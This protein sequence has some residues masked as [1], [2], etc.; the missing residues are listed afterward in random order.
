MVE[1]KKKK[2]MFK[3]KN[4]YYKTLPSLAKK[5][6]ISKQE[7]KQLV[8]DINNNNTTIYIEKDGNVGKY[9]YSKEKPLLLKDFGIKKIR[10]S[11]LVRTQGVKGV[12]LANNISIEATLDLN[13]ACRF[14]FVISEEL[15]ERSYTI[16]AEISSSQITDNY[17]KQ[18]IVD[19]YLDTIAGGVVYDTLKILNFQVSSVFTEQ[20]F[21]FKDMELYN[22][23]PKN[24]KIDNLFNEVITN[25]KW[26]DCVYDF[27][28]S[29]YPKLSKKKMKDLRTIEDLTIWSELNKLKMLCYD[30]NG[31]IVASHYP[32]KKNK[33]KNLVFIAFNNHLYPLKNTTLHKVKK[34][35]NTE[36]EII[37]EGSGM[38]LLIEFLTK[39]ILPTGLFILNDNVVS[40]SHDGKKYV[41]NPHHKECLEI[42]TNMGLKDKMTPHTNLMNISKIIE[43][44]YV[45]ENLKSFLP[46]N[47]RFIKGGY[48]YNNKDLTGKIDLNNELYKEIETIDKNKAYSY[49]LQ[50]LPYLLQTDIKC[51]KHNP[52]FGINDKIIDHYLYI[53]EPKQSSILLPDINI[54]T[55]KH[56]NFCKKEG[57]KFKITEELECNKKENYYT[58]LIKDLYGKVSEKQFKTIINVM[59][60]K[61]ERNNE[62][63]QNQ[64]V[65]K[66][67]NQDEVDRSEGYVKRIK[68][69]D[70]SIVLENTESFEL[71]NQKPIAV[72]VKDTARLEIYKMLCNL[73]V[74]NENILQVKTD[75]I[76]FIPK[77]KGYMKYINKTLE[78]WKIEKYTPIEDHTYYEK[79]ITFNYANKDTKNVLGNCYAGAGKTHT[80]LNEIIPAIEKDNNKKLG[81]VNDYIILTPSH[82]TLKEYRLKKY[83]CNVIQRYS[84]NGDIPDEKHII[85]DEIGMVDNQ[86]WN[87][88]YKLFLK[89]RKIY[90][91]GDFKQL[92]AVDG[93]VYDNEIFLNYIFNKQDDIKTNYRNNFTKKYYDD[94]MNC[95]KQDHLISEMKKYREKKYY[96]AQTIICYRNKTKDKYNDLMCK[97]LKIK[98]MK[99]K[100]TKIIS[101]TNDLKKNGIY[102]KF[103]YE[104][105]GKGIGVDGNPCIEITDGV[106]T[107]NINE[108]QFEKCFNYSYARTLYS[109]QGETLKSLYYP[110]EDLYFLDGRTTYTLISRL[111]EEL[112]DKQKTENDKY[113]KIPPPDRSCKKCK[114]ACCCRCENPSLEFCEISKRNWCNS[115]RGW[116]C[117]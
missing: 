117:C 57:L 8:E 36:I 96:D 87:V 17:L 56:I 39:G 19:E 91:Y 92:K 13:I 54:Y 89:G 109:V 105:S 111:K 34:Q 12:E 59:I 81:I 25:D 79:E 44:V 112:G 113:K 51:K 22:P 93:K 52:K 63:S 77:N 29:Q 98:S 78:G 82:S 30:I 26:K 83:T 3:G 33:M 37:E 106:E 46:Q 86:G 102:N 100:G 47:R 5:L 23:A 104:V 24:L 35:D 74:K 90:A 7:A 31:N 40:F 42:L 76:S 11:N 68:G 28:C 67:C 43:E 27:L 88:I 20:K 32:E 2:I 49:S 95:K 65:K 38:K 110:D 108:D 75:S 80:I 21:K 9:D 103:L 10:A 71:H 73:G 60:G 4:V 55:G 72:Q 94:L 41:D 97:R 6:K 45:K 101:I 99:Q 61:M 70:Y 116:K 15:V 53:V 85:I 14:Q 84:L 114:V 69:T 18:R 62:L 50:S 115:C 48:N 107:H 64:K 1:L 58:N 66:I 16:S